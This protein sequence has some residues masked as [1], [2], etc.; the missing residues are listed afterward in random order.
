MSRALFVLKLSSFSSYVD[1]K[2]VVVA[3]F[4]IRFYVV[5]AA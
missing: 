2:Q 5:F 1:E 3:V 4:L